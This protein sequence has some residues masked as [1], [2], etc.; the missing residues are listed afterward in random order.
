MSTPFDDT[1]K[2][3]L[4]RFAADWL[5]WLAP[6]LELPDGIRARPVDVNLPTV[7]VSADKAF[8]LE[9]PGTGVLHIE[10]QS[11]WDGDLPARVHNYN[12]LLDERVGTPVY[13]VA[14]LLRREANASSITGRFERRYPNGRA[15][16]TFDYWV[17][18][19]WELP[20]DLLL[21][22]GVGTLPLA[23]LADDAEPRLGQVV[24]L[25]DAR[26]AEAGADDITRRLVLTSGFILGGLR[27]D[28]EKLQQA[29]ARARGMKESSTY[30]MILREGRAEAR[31]EDL[32]DILT[33]RFGAVPPDVEHR[34]MAATDAALLKAAI[35]AALHVAKPED[36]PL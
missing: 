28:N 6:R 26:L 24:D 13:S 12:S 4:D 30:Q 16:L 5:T 2:Q 34:I 32:L 1:L 20:A 11:S 19:V 31:Q 27:Y 36:L 10:P 35:K 33:D 15:Y 14:L 8:A 25:V 17:V 22:G 18:R 21:A 9:P 7:Q 23:L 29:F 3:L